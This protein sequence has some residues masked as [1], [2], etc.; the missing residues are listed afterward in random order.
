MLQRLP[1]NLIES[2][3]FKRAVNYLKKEL[4]VY[5]SEILLRELF[6]SKFHSL[7]VVI[8]FIR[9]CESILSNN[10]NTLWH[11]DI[12][13]LLIRHF[14][15]QKNY[16][17]VSVRPIDPYLLELDKIPKPR[18]S[19]FFRHEIFTAIINALAFIPPRT[20]TKGLKFIYDY[21]PATT[22]TGV[23]SIEGIEITRKYSNQDPSL[24]KSDFIPLDTFQSDEEDEEDE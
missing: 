16:R 6:Q 19:H 12:A 4:E 7:E 3:E 8:D 11:Y 21:W 1:N 23:R 17:R 10:D 2:A 14:Y 15:Y 20:G 5:P 24:T 13:K 9:Y 18:G 22:Q